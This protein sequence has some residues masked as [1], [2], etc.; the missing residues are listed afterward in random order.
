MSVLRLMLA[1]Y[2]YT[3]TLKMSIFTIKWCSHKV[4]VD[5]FGDHAQDVASLQCVVAVVVM[6]GVFEDEAALQRVPINL[7]LHADVVGLQQLLIFKEDT[8]IGQRL[9]SDDEQHARVVPFLRVLETHDGGRDCRRDGKMKTIT[10]SDATH[11]YKNT[12]R[13]LDC[14]GFHLKT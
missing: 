11:S 7:S 3:I 10:H 13:F 5:R 6:G 9:A 1:S 12:Q 8:H 14:S 2:F 4:G